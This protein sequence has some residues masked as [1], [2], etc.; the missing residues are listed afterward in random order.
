MYAEAKKE[1]FEDF[2]KQP[3]A[4][5]KLRKATIYYLVY[6]VLFILG[7]SYYI[8]T[9]PYEAIYIFGLIAAFMLI[10]YHADVTRGRLKAL[11]EK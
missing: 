4:E 9:P 6:F 3:G 2:V 5:K 1:E 10:G 7:S 8:L 11:R